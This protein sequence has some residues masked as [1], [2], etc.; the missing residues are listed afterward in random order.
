[1]LVSTLFHFISFEDQV[2]LEE[3]R[4]EDT[5]VDGEFLDIQPYRLSP[6]FKSISTEFTE[7]HNLKIN[8]DGYIHLAVL[9]KN[10]TNADEAGFKLR[11]NFSRWFSSLVTRTNEYVKKELYS[12]ISLKMYSQSNICYD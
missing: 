5:L 9:L 10:I 3:E 11:V 7:P 6:W 8:E 1:M 2:Y 4:L 12:N